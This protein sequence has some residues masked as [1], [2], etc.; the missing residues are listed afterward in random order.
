VPTALGE[1]LVLVLQGGGALGAFQ[2]GAFEELVAAGMVPDWIAG[3]SIGAVNA[4]LIAGNAPDDRLAALHAFWERVSAGLPLPPPLPGDAIR[5]A[6][7]EASGFA[8]LAF[9]R[10]GFFR[11]RLPPPVLWPAG[12]PEALSWY[13][14]GPLR[15]TLEE[16]VDFDRL[17]DGG[18]RVSVGAA[19]VR[20]GRLHFFDSRNERLGPEHILA[21]AALPPAFP[22][23][24][25]DG[26][27]YRDGGIVSNTPVAWVFGERPR[28]DMLILQLD[29]FDAEGPLP[30]S[31]RDVDE[32]AK[33]IRYSSRSELVAEAMCE[34][35]TLRRELD[36]LLAALPAELRDRP[37][38]AAAARHRC[39]ARIT[40]AR[41]VYRQ[42]SWHTP[43]KDYDFSRTSIVEHWQAGAADMRRL[44]RARVFRERTLPERGVTTFDL[45]GEEV[46][47]ARAG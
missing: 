40:L 7:N 43:S 38:V 30:R 37:E 11:P 29:L 17:N 45:D 33:D 9:G 44:L 22:P 32:R 28:P 27:W 42:K 26:E 3:I 39:R 1:Q 2:G 12:A 35:Q 5:E 21:S 13:D 10:P 23:V 31:I 18:I 4:A 34:L 36:A 20:T 24:E 6:W 19:N 25:I 16:L 46:L 14:V 41:I 47:H 15:A 8:S